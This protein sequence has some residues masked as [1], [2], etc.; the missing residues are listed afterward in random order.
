MRFVIAAL[1]LGLL[2]GCTEQGTPTPASR[3]LLGTLF[4]PPAQPYQPYY[5]QAYE[6]KYNPQPVGFSCQRFGNLTNCQ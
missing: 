5:G 3:V 2:A 6:M 1:A 4:G